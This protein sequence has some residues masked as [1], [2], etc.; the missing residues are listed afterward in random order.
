MMIKALIFDFD[1]LIL[2][3]EEPIYL[4]WQEIYQSYGC[5][6][7]LESWTSIIGTADYEFEPISELER[8]VGRQLDRQAL[9]ARQH[10]REAEMIMTRTAMPGVQDYLDDARRLGLNIG[11]ASSS[12]C[13]W[14]TTHL[15]RLGLVD[16]FDTI[17]GS[18]D[19]HRTKPDPQLFLAVLDDL[20]VGAEEAIVLEDSPNGVLAANR[21]G[22][23]CVAV[24]N[25]MTRELQFDHA[26][27]QLESLADVPLEVL[28]AKIN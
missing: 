24:P 28:L 21:A 2:E 27:M 9:Q 18:D 10:Q 26:D 19:V 6:L 16:Y 20:K 3:T 14:V 7:P 25:G 5:H 17:K 11:L 1:G 8:Q 22:I 13:E 15:G 23:Y 12:T 4:A